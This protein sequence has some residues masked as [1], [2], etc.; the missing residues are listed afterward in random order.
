MLTLE[1]KSHIIKKSGRSTFIEDGTKKTR[2]LLVILNKRNNKYS[3]IHMIKEVGDNS[4][5]KLSDYVEKIYGKI[6]A[7]TV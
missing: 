1:T 2:T 7:T 6:V 4:A 5:P 3:N